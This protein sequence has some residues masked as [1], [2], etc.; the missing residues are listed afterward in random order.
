MEP[1]LT[2]VTLGV[3]DL[4]RMVAFYRDGLGW[5]MSSMSQDDVA[6]FR[7]TGTIIALFGWEALA[8]D[9]GL[10]PEGSGFKGFSLAHNVRTRGEVDAVINGAVAAG[11]TLVKAPE[12]VFWGG[13]SGY[14]ADPEGFLWEVAWGPDFQYTP[15]GH[16]NLPA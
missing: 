4:P 2:L 5:P 7:T 1:R 11:G 9:A 12:D 8:A 14:F 10:S 15:A 16:L 3:R 6:F 13:Y